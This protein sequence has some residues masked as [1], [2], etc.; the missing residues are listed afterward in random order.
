MNLNE[1]QTLASR[2]DND[3][4]P[5]NMKLANYALGCTG[6]AGEVSD[7]VKKFVFHGHELNK[8]ELRKELGDTLW[9]IALI[10]KTAGFTLDEVAAANIEKLSKRYKNGF[11]KEDSI[12]RVE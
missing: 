3:K 8:E 9:Y 5:M 12:N 4:E 7:I 2:T 6:E 10:A 1:Y 11:S